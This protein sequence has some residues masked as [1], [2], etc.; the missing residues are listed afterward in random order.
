VWAPPAENR[1][2]TVDFGLVGPS[3]E[4]E[5]ATNTAPEAQPT[6]QRRSKR[7]IMTREVDM[8]HT[9]Q[10]ET[11]GRNPLSVYAWR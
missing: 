11:T 1:T 9:L 7:G 2:G 10:I 8:R 6:T 3:P 5:L 4:Q